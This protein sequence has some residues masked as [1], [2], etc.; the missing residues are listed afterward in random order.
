MAKLNYTLTS[1]D[2]LTKL[3]VQKGITTWSNLLEYITH[4]PYGRTK[5]RGNL[6][7]IIKD[8]KG[9]CSSKHALLKTVATLNAIPNVELI[10]CIYKMNATNTPK[11]G[12]V[13][14]NE[15]I[16][17]IPEAHCYLKI[18]GIAKDFTSKNSDISLLKND[19]L[20]EETI[21]PQQII[22]Y[23]VNFHKAYISNW[24]LEAKIPITF[25]AVWTL[26]ETCIKNLSFKN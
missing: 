16:N 21:E 2:D 18:N 24:L 22:D 12:N 6:L 3:I 4:L 19:I 20:L 26:R 17:Y 1:G 15:I 23:K 25:E 10:L 13:L 7:R 11:I 8:G 5:N 14:E 9:T